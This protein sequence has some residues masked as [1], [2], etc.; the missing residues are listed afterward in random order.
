MPRP[1]SNR[2]LSSSPLREA[3]AALSVAESAGSWLEAAAEFDAL[4]G[5]DAWREDDESPHYDAALLRSECQ[6]LAGLR[7]A[8]QGVALGRALEESLNRHLA[9]I[10]AP[11]LH[12]WALTGTKRLVTAYLDEVEACLRWLAATPLAAIP[13]AEKRRR[14]EQSAKVYGRSALMLSGGA[15]WGF[16]HL[17]VVKALFQEG[18]LPNILSGASTGAMIAAGVCART[19]AE[20]ADMFAHPDQIRRDGLLPV[21]PR[22]AL[23]QRAALDPDQLMAVLRH[24]VGEW[25]FAEAHAR[26]GRTLNISVSPTR[27][28]QKP[29]V[30]SHVTAPDVLV[31]RAALASSALP[32]LF[33]PVVLEAKDAAGRIGPY[34]PSERWVDGSIY[35]DL[36]KLRLARLHNVNHFIVSQ[37]NPHVVP[38][39]AHHGQRGLLPA[40]AG[41]TSA[42][43]RTQGAYAIDLASRATR[44][45]RG[46][47]SQLA[48]RAQALVRQDYRGD[49]DIHPRFR[50]DL[51]RKVVVNPTLEDLHEFI[52]E[53]ERATWP[54]LAMVRDHTRLGRVF[55]ECVGSLQG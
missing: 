5:M 3:A 16:Y 51:L 25:T 39:V 6:H 9:D 43:V 44:P 21:G 23:K 4:T 26:S 32:G 22:Q 33:P 24:N 55:R 34:V 29:R 27:T 38:F 2:R 12:G 40:L 10:T 19:D 13:D 53:G 41:I 37:A 48:D 1:P 30:L 49:I 31:A 50:L 47:L 54:K 11:E 52:Q 7:E 42:T 45:G 35:E 36:P 15:T 17:G 28:R 20:L 14:F 46:P 18:L 8:G